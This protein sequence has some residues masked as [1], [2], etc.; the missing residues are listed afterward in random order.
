M[1]LYFDHAGAQSQ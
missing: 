1:V